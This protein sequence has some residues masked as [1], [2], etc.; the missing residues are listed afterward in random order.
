VHGWCCYGEY[1]WLK[2]H[3]QGRLYRQGY[4]VDSKVVF[5]RPFVC[6]PLLEARLL[7]AAAEKTAIED[8]LVPAEKRE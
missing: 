3:I 1:E 2:A 5:L 8:V 6:C 4:R 7:G